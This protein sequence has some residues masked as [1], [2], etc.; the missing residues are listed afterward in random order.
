MRHKLITNNNCHRLILVFAGWGMDWRVFAHLSHPGYDIMVIWDY[1]ELSFN[2]QPLFKYD[3]ICVI[4]WSMG[5]FAAS[6]TMHEI[7]PRVT[8]RVAVNGTLHPID[9]QRGIPPAIWHGTLNAL[10]PATLRKFHRRMC[11]SAEQF[12]EFQQNS[13]RRTMAELAEELVALETH[14]MFHT[15]Q[16]SCWDMAIISSHDGIFPPAN[17]SRAWRGIAPVRV[18]DSGHLPDFGQI[19]RRLV[20]DK[21]RVSQRF[22]N[23]ASTYTDSAT[24]QHRIAAGLMARFDL[25]FGRKDIVGNVIEIGPG[26]GGH[27]TRRWI[28]RTDPRAKLMLWDIAPVETGTYAPHA[29]F[30][31]CDAEVRI[32]RQAT[33]SA[34]FIFSSST[35]QWFNSP[36]EFIRECERVLVPGGYLV[37]SSFIQGNLEE[38]CSVTG[39]GLQ[40][41]S[42]A[43]WQAMFGPRF[44]LMVAEAGCERIQLET[45]RAVLEHLRDTGVNSVRFRRSA[46][47]TALDIMRNYPRDAEG[48]C[49]LTY[50]PIYLIAQKVQENF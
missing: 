18:L 47:A 49:T 28:E 45:P 27:L 6:A 41:P 11:V 17:Q 15:E 40:L 20:I 16:V 50:R 12:A 46:A 29:V 38:L 14:T 3:E 1:R 21:S 33:A 7:L 10:S 34:A 37:L 22:H 31:Q 36:R 26:T 35:V 44:N 4:A 13:P 5:V 48:K 23:A 8:M 19:I 25:T 32:R 39:N 9:E 30:E 24:I 43:G 2:W 42:R